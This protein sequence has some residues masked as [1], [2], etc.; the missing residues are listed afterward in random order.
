MWRLQAARQEKTR[1][2]ERAA[3]ISSDI[4]TEVKRQVSG[5][6]SLTDA[7]ADRELEDVQLAALR[8]AF[9]CD[10]DS[11]KVWCI[12][13]GRD[14]N[15]MPWLAERSCGLLEAMSRARRVRGRTPLLI[16][17]TSDRVVDTF[18][19]YRPVQVIEAKKM[20]IDERT[21]R[22]SLAQIREGARRAI[23][24]AMRFGQIIVVRM[25]NTAARIASHYSEPTTLP[26][27]LFEHEAIATLG[28]RHTGSTADN[29]YG[30]AHA[31]SACLRE[32]DTEFGHFAVRPGF[33][34]VVTTQLGKDEALELLE[35]AL[36]MR[37]L[38]PIVPTV[39]MPNSTAMERIG[40]HHQGHERADIHS[41]VCADANVDV[42][43]NDR[44]RAEPDVPWS[45]EDAH[46]AAERLARR[47]DRM[48]AGRHSCSSDLTA[49]SPPEGAVDAKE[50]PMIP[51][52][53]EPA[54]TTR[55]VQRP[56]AMK[57]SRAATTSQQT[58][59][60]IGPLSS[61]NDTRGPQI[62][63]SDLSRCQAEDE[64][65]ADVTCQTQPLSMVISCHRRL[66]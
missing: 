61:G 9:W 59:G 13:V 7:E 10:L 56:P 44:S 21:G 35:S 25:A 20:V 48:R 50:R 58:T 2:D 36:P 23:V 12:P 27:A 26:L 19:S 39:S 52:L 17:N 49:Q 32:E 18:F 63:S 45:L 3:A 62:I 65:Y 28:T 53:C 22:R 34:V 16:D 14:L 30:S 64:F 46:A 1:T 29:L 54:P 33:E 11:R 41:S 5:E 31:L 24:N 43:T 4:N 60:P 57:S 15:V 40:Q 42:H 47:V 66:N 51:A 8:K 55:L 6:S 37:V 38:Q